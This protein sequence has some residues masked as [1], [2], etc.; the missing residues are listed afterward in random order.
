MRRSLIVARC[1]WERR[2][3]AMQAAN[4]HV[5]SLGT[6]QKASRKAL[7]QSHIFQ[8]LVPNIECF[9][10]M[11]KLVTD[12]YVVAPHILIGRTA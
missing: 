4:P 11:E 7:E 2:E 9:C 3:R 6:V 1:V 10:D 5:Q 8:T 12:Y